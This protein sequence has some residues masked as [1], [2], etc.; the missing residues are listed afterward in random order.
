MFLCHQQGKRNCSH[1]TKKPEATKTG[2]FRDTPLTL[3]NEFFALMSLFYAYDSGKSTLLLNELR[4]ELDCLWILACE[5]VNYGG[6]YTRSLYS[7]K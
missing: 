3:K 5:P 1:Y 7:G 4:M 2:D 6:E